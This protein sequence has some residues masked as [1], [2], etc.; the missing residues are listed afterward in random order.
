MA[1]EFEAIT[2]IIINLHAGESV[3]E[4]FSC[5]QPWVSSFTT[6]PSTAGTAIIKVMFFIMLGTSIETVAP[7][8][9]LSVNG[10]VTGEMTDDVRMM[11]RASGPFPPNMLIHI[12]A[13]TATGTLYSS[14]MPQTRLGL[15]P[16]SNDPSV[17]AARGMTMLETNNARIR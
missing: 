7:K 13:V 1:V 3:G 4:S 2:P 6:I 11:V 14:T 5:P 15:E 17:W 9:S 8:R 16:K 12:K 10:I